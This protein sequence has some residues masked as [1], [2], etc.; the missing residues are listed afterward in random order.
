M[1]DK[2]KQPIFNKRTSHDNEQL[3][4]RSKI[5]KNKLYSLEEFKNSK[6]IMFYVSF[7]NEVDTH[8][9]IKELLDKKT[10]VVPY[11]VKGNLHLSELKNF[12][13]LEP[14][15]FGILEP[16]EDKIKEF[17]PQKLDLIIVPGIVFDHNGHRVGYSLGYYDKF[18]A[19][20]KNDHTKIGLA[21][22]FQII[23]K[24]PHEQHDVPM[25]IVI[26]EEKIIRCH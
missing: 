3:I 26:T 14:K 8:E 23:E 22:D 19:M 24:I 13:D 21:F 17:D 7:E 18:L 2:I 20:L 12:D 10:I 4:K 25:D 1:K 11:V 5:I 15:T 9:M 16:K 6:N